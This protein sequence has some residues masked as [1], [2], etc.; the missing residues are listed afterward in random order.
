[1]DHDKPI[2]LPLG[3][4]LIGKRSG[5]D[6]I[7]RAQIYDKHGINTESPDQQKNEIKA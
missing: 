4:S 7:K 5:N 3:S 2:V 6:R 1:M